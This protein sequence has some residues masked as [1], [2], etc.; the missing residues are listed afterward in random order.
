MVLVPVDLTHV[1]QLAPDRIAIFDFSDD[2][3]WRVRQAGFGFVIVQGWEQ[4]RIIA[5]GRKSDLVGKARAW[6]LPF[7]S[8]LDFR[9]EARFTAV[10]WF[11][12]S[13]G[14]T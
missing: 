10:G 13:S 11:V 6:N 3:A 1:R 9:P 2:V 12:R 7:T 5:V 4:K 8:C 14:R